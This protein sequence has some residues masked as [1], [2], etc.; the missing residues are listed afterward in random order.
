MESETEVGK[1]KGSRDG[2][3]GLGNGREPREG[4]IESPWSAVAPNNIRLPLHVIFWT[5]TTSHRS[6]QKQHTSILERWT[7]TPMSVA[8]TGTQITVRTNESSQ[9]FEPETESSNLVD[10]SKR[11]TK[12]RFSSETTVRWWGI[13]WIRTTLSSHSTRNVSNHSFEG[14]DV[15][16]QFLPAS[17]LHLPGISVF[18]TR[19]H[20]VYGQW[21]Y[22]FTPVYVVP[23]TSAIFVACES[24]GMD[25]VEALLKS[26]KA[27]IHD[28]NTNGWTLLHVRTDQNT[29]IFTSVQLICVPDCRCSF[30][31]RPLSPIDQLRC[32][33]RRD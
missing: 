28:V 18:W 9:T 22:S 16:K 24:G 3:N 10:H 8:N 30:T 32:E 17:W 21:T 23:S 19:P 26:G 29:S 2:S 5:N 4:E 6:T 1:S 25:E 7:S 15:T 27:S 33:N 14:Q 13:G 31:R 11:P 20:S 12:R